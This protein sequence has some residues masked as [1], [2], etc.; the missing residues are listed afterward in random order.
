MALLR[1]NRGA[2]I[3]ESKHAA[4]DHAAIW[5]DVRLP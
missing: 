2:E 1:E 3:T 4:S 5:V